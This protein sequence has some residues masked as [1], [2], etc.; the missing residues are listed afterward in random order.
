MVTYNT[1]GM[2]AHPSG[3]WNVGGFWGAGNVAPLIGSLAGRPA[4]IC[5][6]A[7]GVFDELAACRAR[8]GLDLAIFAVND[9][10]MYLDRLDHW[11]SLHVENL[12]AWK[13]VRWLHHHAAEYTEYHGP[14]VLPPVTWGWEE[15]TPC[16]ALSGYFALQIAWVMGASPLILCGCP[17]SPTRRFFEATPRADFG[18][19][20]GVSGGDEGVRIQIE[21]EMDRLP[22]FK[23]SV[24]SLSGWTREFFGTA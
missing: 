3:T 24:R 14:R 2:L 11:V 5:G 7:A 13:A 16:Y 10:G 9:V 21:R 20:G 17:G 22:E 15:L 23:A 18:Y 1:G 19:G 8:H 4:A 12:A 6:N